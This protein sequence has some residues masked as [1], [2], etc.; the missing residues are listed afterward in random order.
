VADLRAVNI[1]QKLASF[2]DHWHPR[3]I[4]ELNGQHVKAAKLLGSFAW[5]HHDA[6]DE[7]FLVVSGNLTMRL[8]DDSGERA[9]RVGVGE[10][11]VV[12][13]GVEHQPHADQEVHVVLFEP[14]G[15]VNTGSASDD[16]R[17]RTRLERV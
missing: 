8:R 6:E 9:V 14:A 2:Q 15:T 11:V 5:H 7:L 3:L 16:S 4:G 12:P 10:F 17:T 1:A 13:H